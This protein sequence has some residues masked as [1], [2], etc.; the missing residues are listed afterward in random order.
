MPRL[1]RVLV[2]GDDVGLVGERQ[3]VPRADR[4]DRA[5]HAPEDLLHF[6][7]RGRWQTRRSVDVE[8]EQVGD[9]AGGVIYCRRCFL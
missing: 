4:A 5:L 6:G 8:L 9:D 2:E 7:G 1:D 3:V